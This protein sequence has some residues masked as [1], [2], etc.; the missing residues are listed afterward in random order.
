MGRC[1]ERFFIEQLTTGC[2]STDLSTAYADVDSD[3]QRSITAERQANRRP[4]KTARGPL[5]RRRFAQHARSNQ[6][7]YDLSYR[8][9]IDFQST[10]QIH[11]RDWLCGTYNPE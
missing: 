1:I 5:F 3:E 10:G 4:T 6:R 8:A 7:L 2:G 11:A 9:A